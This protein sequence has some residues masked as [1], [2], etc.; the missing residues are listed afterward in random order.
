VFFHP[1]KTPHILIHSKTHAIYWEPSNPYIEI[2]F[3]ETFWLFSINLALLNEL[4]RPSL[5]PVKKELAICA[6]V[7]QY[8]LLKNCGER[9]NWPIKS[10]SCICA[11]HHFNTII[12]KDHE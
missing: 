6:K 12:F 10:V 9:K 3:P 2:C 11:I 4:T 7:Y 5:P 8:I 1:N